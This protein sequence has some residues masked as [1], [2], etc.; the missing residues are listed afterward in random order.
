VLQFICID[1]FGVA[2]MSKQ[3]ELG[4][5]E[6]FTVSRKDGRDKPGGDRADAK[7]FVLDLTY[8]PFAEDAMF[9]YAAACRTSHLLLSLD[10]VCGLPLKPMLLETPNT[11]TD[12][13]ISG[14][15]HRG[16]NGVLMCGSV[17]IARSNFTGPHSDN[18]FRTEIIDWIC[19]TLNAAQ[20][21]T[22]GGDDD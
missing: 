1:K 7:Y 3:T 16:N 12:A 19:K 18:S 10:I 6:K 21:P 5:Y 13:P 9:A 15:W 17:S 2:Y 4:A 22:I 8:D 11:K 14:N 20:Q